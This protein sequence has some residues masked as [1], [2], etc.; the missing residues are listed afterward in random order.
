MRLQKL[1]IKG[2]KSFANETV[3][4]F[5]ENVTGVVG[6][7]GSGKSNIVDAFRWVLGEQKSKDLRLDKMSSI[8][9]NGTSKKKQGALAQV[10][11][12]FD[13]NKNLLPSEYNSITISR[14]LY[15]NGDSEYRINDVVCRLKDVTTLLL[16]TGMGSDSYAIIALNM[17]DD[18][19]S[20]KDNS[21][22]KMLFQAAGI[23]KY[24]IRKEETI[25]KLK[26]T[27]EDLE[28][29]KDLLFEIESNLKT[30]EKQAKRAEKYFEIKN[31]Y[32]DLSLK[33]AIHKVAH[34][35][36]KFKQLNSQIEKEEDNYRASEVTLK[37]LEAKLEQTKKSNLDKE[38]FLSDKQ[39]ETNE[40]L[41]KI[42]VLEND[43]NVLKERI[44]FISINANNLT[45]TIAALE[46]R[47]QKL[48]EEIQN[49]NEIKEIAIK[50]EKEKKNSLDNAQKN[51]EK[52]RLDH[53]KVKSS[54]DISIQAIQELDKEVF[55]IEKK[56]AIFENQKETILLDIKRSNAAIN[57]RA[58]EMKSFIEKL[59]NIKI[60]AQSKQTEINKYLVEQASIK[61]NQEELNAR[62][63]VE[64]KKHSDLNRVL[65]AKRN[66]YKL[67]L[68]IIE[69]LEGFPESIKYL[70]AN[71]EWSKNVPLLSDIVY[72]KEEYRVALENFLEP[73]LNYY[74]AKDIDEALKAIQ[75]LKVA[76]KGK[77][78]F[79]ILDQIPKLKRAVPINDSFVAAIDCIETEQNYL[80]LFEQLLH[81][82]FIVQEDKAFEEINDKELVLLSA[83]GAYIRKKFAV[84]GGSVGLFEGKKIGRK[85]NLEILEK[86]ITKKEKEEQQLIQNIQSLREQIELTK[87]RNL[88]LII[89]TEKDALNKINQERISLESRLENFNLY[90]KE[91]ES[92]I[93]NATTQL[94]NIEI[95]VKKNIEFHTLK[96]A[97]RTQLNVTFSEQDDSFAK[98]TSLMSEASAKY[99]EN[100]IEFIKQQNKLLGINRELEYRKDQKLELENQKQNKKTQQDVETKEVVAANAQLAAIEKEL[101]K[102][103]SDKELRETS[104][105]EA[106]AV[107]FKT[108]GHLN[109]IEEQIRAFNKLRQESQLLINNLKDKFNDVKFQLASVG[110]RLQI[111]FKIG[112]N[113]IIN[114]DPDLND[115]LADIEANVDKLRGRI[116]N[117]G[118]VNPMAVEAYN[119]INE[120]YILIKKQETDIIE[121]KDSLM[122]TIVEIEKT[123]TQ[124]YLQSFEKIRENFI[125]VFRGLFTADDTCDLILVNPENPLESEINIIAKP[126]G[127]RPQTINQLSGGEKTLTAIALLFA[128]YLL[129][130]APFCI[131]DEV[132]APLDDTNIEKF[133]KI[134]KTFSKDS[135]FIIVTHNK[136]TMASVD[137]IYGVFMPEQG[138]STVSA[139]DFRNLEHSMVLESV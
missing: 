138:I 86:K 72:C 61:K 62:F 13:N 32:K 101:Q 112:I 33:L 99:N 20:D 123:A 37:Q 64:N 51:L 59:E 18:L 104:L 54:I 119:E 71:K 69:N 70:A 98:A 113:E 2:F 28:R 15:R 89:E 48:N 17:V 136:A 82:V 107:Y 97:K 93:A 106:E 49:F 57:E 66:E 122:Q 74:V 109:D 50:E 38:K 124:Q 10:S 91:N 41:S 58:Q 96:T 105:T 44:N 55:E 29:V 110:E 45:E 117:F 100:N 115:D 130:P 1:E 31:L 108:R 21:R 60:L 9:F 81:K 118:E 80:P 134:I 24:K 120:R 36:E 139:V 92:K 12:S 85:K 135:Q 4:H 63:E 114:K 39:K 27:E 111:E 84:S 127:K 14:L 77:A 121:A 6:P 46:F 90:K 88:Q 79:I 34:T 5:H 42:R 19:L 94:K 75:M 40:L 103:Y 95:D 30:L 126:K 68:S 125:E 52:I 53:S 132:D 128:L 26:A 129:K 76:Q 23:T 65:D 56:T 7:N 16:D 137:V 8:I 83:N 131:F 35:K 22:Q 47:F 3:I 116:E 78:N 87:K 43:R 73:Y 25:R 11:L 67:T 102:Q 133:N